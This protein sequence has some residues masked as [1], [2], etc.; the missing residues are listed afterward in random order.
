MSEVKKGVATKKLSKISS[1]YIDEISD[2]VTVIGLAKGPN[3]TPSV[4]L[5]FSRT[6]VT[7]LE[8]A[9]D[10]PFDV[11]RLF[12]ANITLTQ[13]NARTLAENILKGLSAQ[14]EQSSDDE[15]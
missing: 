7:P 1:S 3:G 8:E 9:E 5:M 4:S 6:T 13:K 10:A 12:V 11:A 2:H 15:S 14:E